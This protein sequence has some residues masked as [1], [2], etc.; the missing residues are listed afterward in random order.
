VFVRNTTV[1]AACVFCGG[2]LKKES[3]KRKERNLFI[4]F[5][6]THDGSLPRRKGTIMYTTSPYY[7][8]V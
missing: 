3:I 2:K 5:I 1:D 4:K 7:K 6:L 8:V